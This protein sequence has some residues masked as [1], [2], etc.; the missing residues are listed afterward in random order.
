MEGAR[1]GSK[2][3]KERR[4]TGRGQVI[5][6]DERKMGGIELLGNEEDE[7]EF[8]SIIIN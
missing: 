4:K 2:K 5:M 3:K 7:E 1:E 8:K 6:R